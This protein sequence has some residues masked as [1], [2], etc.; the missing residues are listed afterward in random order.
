MCS[1]DLQELN[2]T[3]SRLRGQL[4]QFEMEAEAQIQYRLEETSGRVQEDFDPLEFDRFTQMQTLSRGMLE[5]LNDLDSLR[6]IL[7]NLTRESETLL[8][9]QARVNTE[10]QEGLDRKSVV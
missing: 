9:Q 4:R 2:D 8:V 6:G 5:S 3:I 10:L 1:S 7:T